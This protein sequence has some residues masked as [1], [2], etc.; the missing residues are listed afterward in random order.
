MK[1]FP[2]LLPVLMILFTIS[3]CTDTYGQRRKKKQDDQPTVVTDSF[4]LT[5][6]MIA[7][8]AFRSLGPAAYS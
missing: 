1:T 7:H 6:Q 4:E 5:N 2:F 8:L 3:V